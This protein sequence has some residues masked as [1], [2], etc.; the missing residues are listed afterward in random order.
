MASVHSYTHLYPFQ[1]FVPEILPTKSRTEMATLK[2]RKEMEIQIQQN[3]RERLETARPEETERRNTP[4]PVQ[5]EPTD[6]SQVMPVVHHTIFV[7]H[8]QVHCG[9]NL[10]L[11]N[12]IISS[13]A[14]MA[15][16]SGPAFNYLQ[17]SG[18]SLSASFR[19]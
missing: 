19:M 11:D 5:A 7:L 12:L 1:D 18:F 16:T 3:E 17:L 8:P 10:R 9:S 4:S 2:R 15:I 13:R 6:S 14:L